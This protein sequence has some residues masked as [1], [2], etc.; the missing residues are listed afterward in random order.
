[1]QKAI[2]KS[3][4]FVPMSMD[5]INM[6]TVRCARILASRIVRTDLFWLHSRDVCSRRPSSRFASP[7]IA[8]RPK[9]NAQKVLS[10]CEC[11]PASPEREISRNYSVDQ[12]ARCGWWV[13]EQRTVWERA[14]ERGGYAIRMHTYSAPA[15]GWDECAPDLAPCAPAWPLALGF[16]HSVTA[17]PTQNHSPSF[18]LNNQTTKII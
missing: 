18:A 2:K 1:M 5:L 15:I 6:I 9:T 11:A 17:R 12:A 13:P 7:S 16:S 10:E 3:F 14:S 4:Y 8:H